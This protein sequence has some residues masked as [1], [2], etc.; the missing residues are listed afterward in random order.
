MPLDQ[1]TI[2]QQLDL[3][4]THR[5]TLA[6]LLTQQAQFS[7]GHIPAHVANGITEARAA[8][9]QLKVDLHTAGVAVDDVPGDLP[10]TPPIERRARQQRFLSAFVIVLV[11]VVAALEVS[12]GVAGIQARLD[13][14]RAAAYFNHGNDLAA[15][16]DLTGAV[17]DYDKAIVLDPKFAAAYFYR[18]LARAEQGDRARAIADY[19][20]AIVLDP[21][22]PAAYYNRGLVFQQ[23]GDQTHAIAD[24]EQVLRLTGDAEQRR[25]AEERLR[26]LGK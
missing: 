2:T 13:A 18:G 9:A 12:G 1:D 20:K 15:Q 7:I 26:E 22:G 6:H 19:D 4:A 3:L 5:R 21:K 23:Q 25:L 17:A 14:W 16:G 24:F 8:I 11:L 10:G